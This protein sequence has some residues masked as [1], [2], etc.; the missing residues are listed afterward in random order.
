MAEAAPQ[1]ETATPVA[2]KPVG[3]IEYTFSANVERQPNFSRFVLNILGRR[4]RRLKSAAKLPC[5]IIDA[6][7]RRLD[8]DDDGDTEEE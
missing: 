1:I 2:P 4:G 6:A 5:L 3:W 8:D 7:P